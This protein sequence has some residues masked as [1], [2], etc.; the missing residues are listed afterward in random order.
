MKE[1][2]IFIELHGSRD[3]ASRPTKATSR[4]TSTSTWT[5]L[6]STVQ[7]LAI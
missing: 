5:Y 6:S 7:V 1:I 2:M 3:V 4:P